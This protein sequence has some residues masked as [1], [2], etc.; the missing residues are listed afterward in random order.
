MHQKEIVMDDQLTKEAILS[1]AKLSDKIDDKMDEILSL[2]QKYELYKSTSKSET[3][4]SLRCECILYF[5][6]DTNC[7]G[8][9]AYTGWG[10]TMQL[11]LPL[12]LLW[13]DENTIQ[14][15]INNAVELRNKKWANGEP[16]TLYITNPNL[17][18]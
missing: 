14:Q 1:Y 13:S 15:W 4:R 12:H 18:Y 9:Q 2:I 6:I 11:S 10:G 3:V 7:I 5:N 17:K 8:V 16:F